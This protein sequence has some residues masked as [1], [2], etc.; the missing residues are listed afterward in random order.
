MKKY[1][2]LV[3]MLVFFIPAFAQIVIDQSDMPKEG[4]T[5]RVSLTNVIP[6]DYTLTGADMTWDFSALTK[7]SQQIDSFVNI[8]STPS[9]YWFTFIPGI[10]SNLAS[11][12]N[13][14][15]AI[16]GLPFSNYFNFL[17]KSS[18][19][20]SDVGYAF[21]LSVIPITLKYDSP[22]IY[23]AFPCTMGSTWN[24]NSF[25][26]ISLPGIAY[27]SSS[28]SRTSTVDGWGS[29]A[30]PFGTFQTIRIKS[31]VI[32]HDSIFLDTLGFGIPYTRNITEYKWL[33]K[34]QGIP[35][36]QINEE[37]LVKSAVYRDIVSHTGV[38]EIQKESLY[39]FPNP[40]TGFCTISM[41]NHQFPAHI[42]VMNTRGSIVMEE[43]LPV[44]GGNS[45]SFD[46]SGLPP[47]LYM[48]RWIEKEVVYTGKVLI[49]TH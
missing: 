36:L 15:P 34:G 23:Y 47:G 45:A 43:Y 29:L 27:F 26:S 21:Q 19:Q 22:D 9:I 39:V 38:N 20:F 1:C 6:G 44:S 8:M 33:G 17:K 46:L 14:L 24:S 30:T 35:L 12:G 28:R 31:E 25:A 37:G 18:A 3:A 13:N 49:I 2:I 40:S 32:E 42:Q 5:L 4:D 11:P 7:I 10:V 41:E 16:P 48:I